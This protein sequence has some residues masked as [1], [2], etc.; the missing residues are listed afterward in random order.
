LVV[1]CVAEVRSSGLR[2]A[3]GGAAPAKALARQVSARQSPDSTAY[4][5]VVRP[6]ID[7]YCVGCHNGRLKTAGLILDSPDLASFPASAPVWEKV[8]NKLRTQAMPPAGVP[9][10]DGATYDAVAAA[11]EQTLDHAAAAHPNPGRPPIHRLSRFEYGNVIRD[12]LG[13]EVD[14]RSLLPP[15]DLSYGFDNIAAVLSLSPALMDRY[16]SAARLI[17]R[18]AVGDPTTPPATQVYRLLEEPALM[19]DE[20]MGDDLPFGTRGGV[21][22]RHHFP[23]DAEYELKIRLQRTR[24]GSG[25]IRGLDDEHQI[26]V[27]LDRSRVGLL[28]V[29]RRLG[30]LP[31]ID[32]LPPL[33]PPQAGRDDERT[34]Y[35]IHADDELKVR[36]AANA[37]TRLLQ[38]AFL[39]GVF[40]YEGARLYRLPNWGFAVNRGGM[41]A[42]ETVSITGPFMP[43][44]RGDTESRRKLFVCR[45]RS[46]AEE[47]GCAERI[48]TALARR[49]YRRPVS[50]ADVDVLVEFYQSGRTNGDFD[51]GIEAALR[52][53]LVDPEFLFRVERPPVGAD[54]GS[55]YALNDVELASRLS[56]FLWSSMP[57]EQLLRLASRGELHTRETLAAEVRRMLADP[58]A[59]ALVTNFV[60]QW[61]YLRNMRTVTPD[62]AVFPDFNENLRA[63]FERETELFVENTL[64]EDRSVVD[65]LSAD[66]TFLNERLAT[67]YG[68]PGVYGSHFRRVQLPA[69]APRGGL[70]GQASILTATSY[71]TRTAPTIR[72]K[73]LLDNLLGAPPPPPPPNVPALAEE[74]PGAPQ[75]SMRERME[76]HRK[77]P[78]C[79]SCHARMDPLGFA[80][81]NFDGIGRWRDAEGSETINSEGVL[82]DGARFDGPAELRRILISRRREFVTA[83][84]EK[85]MTY[86]LGRGVEYFDAPAIRNVVRHADPDFRWSALIFGVVNSDPFRLSR[87]GGKESP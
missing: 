72:G 54:P 43:T 71:S 75:R 12:L 70:L 48:L 27:R 62:P 10:P 50:R 31:P 29:G 77:N 46:Q 9:R 61:L 25:E 23:L 51:A 1:V 8:V 69:S 59:S 24:D 84:V 3:G 16:L 11:L 80:L 82:P 14:V 22:V 4:A 13:L 45:P 33:P 35:E 39:D 73:W 85:L 79:A 56:F 87:A 66:Y 38:V 44:G 21:A 42:I 19:Q 49:A 76:A 57:D 17:S 47:R 60:G 18:L 36:F 81:E 32:N 63:D 68:I 2:A 34:Q 37:G 78:A 52:R 5:D 65:L 7:R 30:D 74:A 58:R 86:A 67:H 6:V 53:V 41:P 26:D 83:V 20:R 15:D 40:K 28:T 55:V 64:R